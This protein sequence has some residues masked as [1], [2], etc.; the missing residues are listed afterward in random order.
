MDQHGRAKNGLPTAQ[1]TMPRLRSYII[2]GCILGLGL[3]FGGVGFG[4]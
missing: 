1:D 2:I 3:G 4:V